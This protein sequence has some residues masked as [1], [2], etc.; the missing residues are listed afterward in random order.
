MTNSHASYCQDRDQ[1]SWGN[2]VWGCEQPLPAG[3]DPDAASWTLVHDDPC[4][5]VR[6][7]SHDI[8]FELR[9]LPP[10][11]PGDGTV[12][13]ARSGAKV[14]VPGTVWEQKGYE[15]SHSYQDE[16]VLSQTLYALVR[17]DQHLH[18]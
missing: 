9:L 5:V 8:E 3:V 7:R 11:D 12:P 6:L 1:P 13:A 2:V 17:M 16:G 18:G 15:H 14:A 10:S 4:G